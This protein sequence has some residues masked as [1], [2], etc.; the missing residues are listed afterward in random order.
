MTIGFAPSKFQAALLNWYDGARRDLP[1]RAKPGTRPDPYRVWLSEIMLQ[2]TTVKAVIPY[3]ER[4]LARWPS[5]KALGEAPRDEVLAAW[6]GLGYYT[7]ARNLHACAQ[8]VTRDGFPANEADLRGLPGIGAYTAAAIASIAFGLPAAAV[9]G[10]AERVLARLCALGAPLPQGRKQ[11]RALAAKLVPQRRPGDY[12]Q[13]LM[14]L[15]ATICTPRSPSCPD[16]PVRPYC[17]AAA[18]G[19]PERYPVKAPKAVRPLRQGEAFVI[20]RGSGQGREILLRRRP[21]RGLL[22]GMMEVPCSEWVAGDRAA[23]PCVPSPN[24]RQGR[25]VQHVFTHFHLELRVFAASREEVLAEAQAFGGDWAP[26]A[27]L[28]RFALPAV[29]KK[30]VASGLEALGTP[31]PTLHPR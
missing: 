7:R 5:V 24:W 26:L 27:G 3:F 18:E 20:A 19:K 11:L 12:A 4:F 29:M 22:G 8:A 16:C 31:F 13:A 15:G 1:W 10:N 17:A 21:E 2:Q 9:D 30:A 25:P 28:A 6:A 23:E 14:D